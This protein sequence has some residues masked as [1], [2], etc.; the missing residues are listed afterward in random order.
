M[1]GE[2]QGLGQASSQPVLPGAGPVLP[3][4][5]LA[6]LGPVSALLAGGTRRPSGRV[7]ARGPFTRHYLHFRHAVGQFERRLQRVGQ[8]TLDP[9]AQDKPVHHEA[10]ADFFI[11]D[12][13]VHHDLDGVDLVT[14]Q[15]GQLGQLVHGAVNAGAGKALAGQFLDEALVLALSPPHDGRQDLET[16]ALGKGQDPVDYLLG[17]LAGDEAAVLG[18]M[19]YADPGIEQAQVV[20]NLRD[21]AHRA[22]GVARRRLLVDR[23]CRRQAL[24]EVH[25]RLVHLAE[26]LTGIRRQR[27]HVAPLSLR[28]NGVE[29]QAALARARQAGED[30]QP[31]PRQVDGHV[32]QVVLPGSPDDEPVRHRVT[33]LPAE[34]MFGQGLHQARQPPIVTGPDQV[35]PPSSVRQS[36]SG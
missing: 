2:S 6:I 5:S 20:V 33:R 10:D 16:G 17:R 35:A 27:L 8:P 31:V 9:G 1:L 26:E 25:V 14:G 34:H 29:S 28:V 19:G 15:L 12:E 32:L 13:P 21:G 11:N 7:A 22:A 30:D 36:C 23:Y 24:D 3:G 4:A 18:T